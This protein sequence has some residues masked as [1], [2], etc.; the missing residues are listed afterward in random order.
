MS[1]AFATASI[2]GLGLM[3]GSLAHDLA[4]RGVRVRAFDTDERQLDEAI[5][6]G[7]VDG[8]LRNDL[9]DIAADLIVIAV[10]VDAAV[11]VLR[12]AAPFI[13]NARL[14]TDLGSTKARILDAARELGLAP[15]FVGSHPMAGNHRSG[16]E[17]S[18]PGLFTD[19]RVYLCPADGGEAESL[20]KLLWT[21]LGASPE[22]IA[23][24]EHDRRLAWSSHLPHVAAAAIA[25]AMADA[26]I[27]RAELGPGGRDTT[28]L[29]GSSPEMWTAIAI[30]NAAELDS[31]LASA[32]REIASF[33]R[34]LMEADAGE[35]RRRFATARDWFE[36]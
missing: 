23:P 13:G 19:A 8:K 3:G 25:L 4:A 11:D 12:R 21:E 6:A 26:G 29:A 10:P 35:V 1:P 7:V 28:R 18:R 33:R 17:A 24:D 15:R 14:V 22:T 32:E 9:E 36:V 2:V 5:C 30:E 27:A 16:W 34:A 20:A 31:A